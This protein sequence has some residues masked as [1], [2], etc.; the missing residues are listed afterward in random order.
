M[1]P[2]ILAGQHIQML[3]DVQ[4][5]RCPRNSRWCVADAGQGPG[6]LT[7]AGAFVLRQR[8][9]RR[10]KERRTMIRKFSTVFAGHVDLPERGLSQRRN[11]E[12]VNCAGCC[13]HTTP[14]TASAQR[15]ML[16]QCCSGSVAAPRSPRP[17]RCVHRQN[18]LSPSASGTGPRVSAVQ[19]RLRPSRHPR[20]IPRRQGAASIGPSRRRPRR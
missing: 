9:V 6:L 10:P 3:A 1:S 5:A 4:I 17:V 15:R 16:R 14:L 18:H 11:V 20:P 13:S 12:P 7:V 8:V 2:P 19:S